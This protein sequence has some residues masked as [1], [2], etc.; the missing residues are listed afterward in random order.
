M[1]RVL[2]QGADHFQAGAVADVGEPGVAVTAEV[3]L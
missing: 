1:D 3:A 2:L